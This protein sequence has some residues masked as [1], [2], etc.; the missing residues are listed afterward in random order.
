MRQA[1]DD[2]YILSELLYVKKFA[3]PLTE[4]TVAAL[5]GDVA[6]DAV[7]LPFA[8]D[9]F[10]MGKY[11]L[12]DVGLKQSAYPLGTI[13]ADT[14]AIPITRPADFAHL[15]DA[16]V[17]LCVEM[18]MGYI[19]DGGVSFGGSSS[20]TSISAANARGNIFTSRPTMGDLTASWGERANSLDNIAAA[21][22]QDEGRIKGDG[23][24]GDPR[25]LLTHPETMLEQKDFFYLMAGALQNG[26]THYR[27]LFNPKPTANISGAF[28]AKN[29][30]MVVPV[31]CIYTH[32]LD[33]V[34]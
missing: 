6:V 19:E 21:Y 9:G 26:Q 29:T 5:T 16:V 31:S 32:H 1:V 33:W 11:V 22:G 28:G 10:T 27:A 2:G 12:V 7:A 34:I 25:R 4:P 30:P 24:V 18:H 13:P 15:E 8:K 17:K 14:S 23:D 20:Q 3:V